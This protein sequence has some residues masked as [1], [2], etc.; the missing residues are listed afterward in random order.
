MAFFAGAVALSLAGCADKL[1]SPAADDAEREF[2]VQRTLALRASV[3]VSGR[4]TPDQRRELE[5]IKQDVVAWQTRT[6][7]DDLSLS[8]SRPARVADTYA[9]ITKGPSA[10]T[11]CMPCPPV[12]ANGSQICFLVEGGP[13]PTG[14]PGDLGLQV[15]AYICINVGPGTPVKSR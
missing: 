11:P 3:T 2:L 7:R 15:C 4:I 12:T 5:D 1:S 6:G 8:T 10:P 13:C 9:V 14:A